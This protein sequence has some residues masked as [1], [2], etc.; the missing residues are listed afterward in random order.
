MIALGPITDPTYIRPDHLGRTD[1]AFLRLIRDERDLPF[2]HLSLRISLTLVPLGVLLYLPFVQGW[3]WAL[4]AVVYQYLNNV[5]YKG[6]FGLMLH[7]TSHR[8]LFRKEYDLLNHYIPWVLAPFFGHSP[9]T[10]YAHHIGMHHAENN[11]EDDDST[12]MPYQRDSLRGFA[13][14]FG[15]FLFAGIYHLAAYF[16]MKKRKRLLYRSVRG[17][18]LFIAFCTVMCLVDWPATLVVFIIPFVLFRLVAMMGNWAQH[19]FLHEADPANSYWNS[20]TCINTPYNHKC[21]NDGYHISHHIRPAMHW[22]EHP[23]YFQRTLDDYVRHDAIVFDGIHFLHVFLYLMRKRYDLLARHFVQLGTSQ[24]TEE[25]VIRMLRD[26]TRPLPFPD[27]G[28]VM[29]AA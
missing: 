29:Q 4:G 11:L 1:R 12:T 15:R 17:E 19:A 21:W 5:V 8:K 22:T 14:Y 6:P 7:C 18:L 27:R 25:E 20:I 2:I 16:F 9:E 24:R 3:W 26:R 23:T 13:H 10:Y 28:K